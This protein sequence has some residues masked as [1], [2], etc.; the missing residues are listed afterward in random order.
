VRRLD[1]WLSHPGVEMLPDASAA[2]EWEKRFKLLMV[3]RLGPSLVPSEI[4]VP[5]SQ[6]G[7]VMAEIESKIRQPMIKEG[8]VVRSQ[9]PWI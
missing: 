7:A 5:L 2:H 9:E 3:K 8:I 6:L 4:V 1:A